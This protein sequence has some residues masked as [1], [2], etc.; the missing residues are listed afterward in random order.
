MTRLVLVELTRLRWRRAVQG[1]LLAALLLTVLIGAVAAWDTRPLSAQEQQRIAADV[2]RETRA[3]GTQQVLRDC[4]ADPAGWGLPAVDLSDPEVVQEACEE[5][6][7]PQPEW[8]GGRPALDL[9]RVAAEHGVALATVLCGLVLLVGTTFAGHDWGTG[10]M[11]N[12]LLV[13]PRRARVWAAKVVAAAVGALAATATL[14]GVFAGGLRLVAAT[15]DLPVTAADQAALWQLC[16]R[17]ALVAVAAAVVSC[18][19]TLLVRSTV[20]ALG[21]LFAALA[22]LPVVLVTL[23]GSDDA[24]TATPA[25]RVAAVLADGYQTFTDAGR[26][27]VLT[28]GEGGRYLLVLAVLVALPSLLA[29]RRADVA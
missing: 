17:T 11:T 2:E 18:T 24:L 21:V 8:F 28:A 4:V 14:L 9:E 22:V 25:V 23:T 15:R 5:A 16:W 26:P 3:P 29:F 13:E 7:L 6:V 19:L 1:L 20:A 27:E 12:Q 10:S